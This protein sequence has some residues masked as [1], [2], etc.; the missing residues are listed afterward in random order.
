[1]TLEAFGIICRVVEVNIL[2]KQYEYC[3]ELTVGTSLNKLERHG[4]DLAMALASST[5]KVDLQLPI[6]GRALV[7]LRVPKP[8]QE[9]IDSFKLKKAAHIKENKWINM[10]ALPFY[11]IGEAGHYIARKIV[12]LDKP[13]KQ[14]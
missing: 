9:Y 7:G 4:R 10:L 8:S 3:I 13:K 2:E 12:E 11:F 1:M 6:P 5:G 14:L